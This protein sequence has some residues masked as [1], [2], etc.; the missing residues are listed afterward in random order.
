MSLIWAALFFPINDVTTTPEKPPAYVEIARLEENKSR[1]LTYPEGFKDKQRRLYPDL[2]P[3]RLTQSPSK[4]F[5]QVQALAQKQTGWKIIRADEANFRLEA[6]A[7]SPLL[8]FSDDVVIEVRPDTEGSTLHMRSKSR[9]SQGDQ[10]VNHKRIQ[11]FL[12]LVQK[13]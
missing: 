6:V 11:E 3:L 13:N 4:V 10:G 2:K 9:I 7:T 1:N 12:D 8:K 5:K